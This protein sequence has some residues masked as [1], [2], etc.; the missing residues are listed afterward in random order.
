MITALLWAAVFVSDALLE[1]MG[2]RYIDARR[3]RDRRAIVGWAGAFAV[4]AG[5]N[6]LGFRDSGWWGLVPAVAGAMVGAY[7]SIPVKGT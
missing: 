3:D 4:I 5:V 6:V 1:Y 2:G 7:L